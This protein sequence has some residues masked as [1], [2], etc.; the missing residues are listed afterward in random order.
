MRLFFICLFV[1]FFVFGFVFFI[2]G[3]HVIQLFV[4]VFQYLYKYSSKVFLY[5]HDY[6]FLSKKN[7]VVKS[8]NIDKVEQAYLKA[9]RIF[10]FFL[11]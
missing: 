6:S 5:D 2:N 1:W 4:C 8:L 9:S 7:P 3:I 11:E 10:S